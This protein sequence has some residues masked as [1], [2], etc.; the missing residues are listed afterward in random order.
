[1]QAHV[2][3]LPAD[4]SGK[5]GVCLAWV[6]VRVKE[7]EREAERHRKREKVGGGQELC[8]RG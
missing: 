4:R 7:R 2:I 5:P 8:K 3:T 1:M 6:C